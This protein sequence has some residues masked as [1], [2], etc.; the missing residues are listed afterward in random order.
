M[1]LAAIFM[2]VCIVSTDAAAVTTK[3]EY[4]L[5]TSLAQIPA[6]GFSKV[7]QTVNGTS[8]GP[9]LEAD[10]GD[11][12]VVHL[13]NRFIQE[14]TTIHWHGMVQRS[15]P[16]YDG[17]DGIAQNGIPPGA[18]F[19]YR[20]K[21]EPAGTHWYHSHTGTQYATGVRGLLIIRDPVSDPYAALPSVPIFFHDW[22]WPRVRDTLLDLISGDS[23]ND[24]SSPVLPRVQGPS[25]QQ[26]NPDD[27]DWSDVKWYGGLVNGQSTTGVAYAK[28]QGQPG[29]NSGTFDFGTGT[30][31]APT[32]I[33][34]A[35]GKVF[36]ME[37]GRTYR[38][39]LCQ[40]S[41]SWALAVTVEGHNLTV[42]AK[43]G[44]LIRPVQT[45]TIMMDIGERYDVL[46]K[47][48][49]AGNYSIHFHSF[50]AAPGQQLPDGKGGSFNATIRVTDGGP[51]CGAAA[52]ATTAGE[53]ADEAAPFVRVLH[54]ATS[55]AAQ[56]LLV[57]LN[58][59][60]TPPP[61]PT[62]DHVP[63]VLGG[64]M[65]GYAWFING[66]AYVYPSP[67]LIYLSHDLNKYAPLIPAEGKPV[68]VKV[69]AVVDV[70]IP[71]LTKMWH[72]LHLH[73]NQFWVMAVGPSGTCGS[74]ANGKPPSQ[75]AT[76][77]TQAAV[78]VVP[79]ARLKQDSIGVPPLGWVLVRF[80]AD[81]PG[82]WFFHCHIDF[83]L[84]RGMAIVFLVGDGSEQPALPLDFPGPGNAAVRPRCG[85]A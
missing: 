75:C 51:W 44:S 58:G 71:N 48:C 57:P 23:A 13:T 10:L 35:T 37:V 79:G 67:A 26:A 54:A 66:I 72:P 82:V 19:T 16:F 81:N 39:R 70:Y 41:A 69:G 49:A 2:A 25:Q 61:E 9:T 38:L 43:D 73:G 31:N 65:M 6:D 12:I 78:S 22:E 62:G 40:G 15:T 63:A 76:N 56:T 28:A 32:P 11:E 7:L 29:N 52:N 47:P 1:R 27:V 42:I 77:Y 4:W 20:F 17:V 14:P 36:D 46:V 55:Q 21:A 8:V 84:A 83:H 53:G 18:T 24:D 33:D 50:N 3:R 45:S 80:A 59:S 74:F 34:Y 5:Y 85:R 68:A 64:N 60:T 30:R